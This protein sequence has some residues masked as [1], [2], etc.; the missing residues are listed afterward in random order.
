[1]ATSTDSSRPSCAARRPMTTSAQSDGSELGLDNCSCGRKTV[2][3]CIGVSVGRLVHWSTSLRRRLRIGR[4]FYPL[5]N[6]RRYNL[7]VAAGCSIVAAMGLVAVTAADD[8]T[9]DENSWSVA[10]DPAL[11]VNQHVDPQF[12]MKACGP[13]AVMNALRFSKGRE[14]EIFSQLVGA[15]DAVRLRFLIDRWFAGRDSLVAIKTKRYG[16]HGCFTQDLLAGFNEML[17][18]HQQEPVVGQ[19]LDR[20]WSEKDGEKVL[21]PAADYVRRVHE[22]LADSLRDGLP[23]VISLRSFVARRHDGP[24]SLFRWEMARAHYVVVTSVPKKL[25][26]HDLGFRFEYV[27]S[28]GAKTGSAWVYTEKHLSFRAFRGSNGI[29]E[30]LDGK[31]FLLVNAPSIYSLQP[32]NAEWSDRTIVTLDYAIYRD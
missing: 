7:V 17:G 2:D 10:V 31:P 29:G 26:D 12:G 20:A 4:C 5:E 15:K 8:S 21:E 9:E 28:N 6:L 23:P 18:E 13:A 1:M 30:W 11:I 22:L 25:A 16:P 19:F 14:A 3:R 32:K 27:D 24:A